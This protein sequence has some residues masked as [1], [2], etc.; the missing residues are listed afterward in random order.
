MGG[1]PDDGVYGGSVRTA[2]RV[3]KLKEVGT[4]F[5]MLRWERWYC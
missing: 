1:F 2:T 5:D 4:W 3:G